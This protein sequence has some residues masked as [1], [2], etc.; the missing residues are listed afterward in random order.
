MR[1]AM[2]EFH[3]HVSSLICKKN[4]NVPLNIPAT[5]TLHSLATDSWCWSNWT[6]KCR[7]RQKDPCF[8]P[9]KNSSRSGS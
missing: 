6:S 3:T 2:L 9:T 8:H 1:N 7:T 5:Q 4:D